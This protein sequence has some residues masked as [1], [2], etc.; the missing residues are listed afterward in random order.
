MSLFGD[1]PEAV[2]TEDGGSTDRDE[3]ESNISDE[4]TDVEAQAWFMYT[5][6]IRPCPGCGA[7][8]NFWVDVRD[9]ICPA[10]PSDDE[11]HALFGDTTD[12][13]TPNVLDA[14]PS[15]VRAVTHEP[16]IVFLGPI[17]K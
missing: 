4:P 14:L 6:R 11:E 8:F 16:K 1:F 5:D 9:H 17:L 10:W 2:P 3:K 7:K 13:M 12:L 15:F